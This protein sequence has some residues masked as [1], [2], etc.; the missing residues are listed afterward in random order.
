VKLVTVSVPVPLRRTFEYSV[1]TAFAEQLVPGTRVRVPFGRRQLIGVVLAAP[2]EVAAPDY[3][4]KP[5]TEVLDTQPALPPELFELC[6]WTADYYQHPIGEVFAAVLPGPLRRGEALATATD[7]WLRLGA[8]GQ[9][10]LATLPARATALRG[11]LEALADAPL[12]RAS[13][14]AERASAGTA[15]RRALAEGWVEAYEVAAQLPPLALLEPEPTL[16][17][18]QAAALAA[19]AA[20]PEGF[21]T[22][23]L[24]GVT[25]SGKTE[26]YLRLTAQVLAAGRQVLVLAPEI[27]LTPQLAERFA[28]RFGAGVARFHSG[29]GETERAQVWQAARDGTVRVIVGTRSAVFVPLAAP[30]LIIVDEEHDVSYKQQD[31]LRYA[32]RDVAVLR[33]SRL[34]VPV[35]LGSATP[36][37]ESRANAESGRYRHVQ[38]RSRVQNSAPPTIHLLDV[39]Q[40]PLE[41]GLSEPLL[42]AVARH[43][44]AGNQA[45]L[46]LNRRGYA[47]VLLCHDCGWMLPCPNCDARLVLH[48]G[49]KRMACHHCG[50]L[51]SVP[52]TCGDCGGS[53]LVPVGQGT[54]RIEEALRLRF[55]EARVERFDSDRLR[56]AAQMQKLF[57]DVRS[58]AVNLL[59]GTQVLAKGHDFAGLTFAGLVDVDQALY[60]SDFR[61]LERMGQLV[62]QVAG[63]V[64]R[65][66]QPG[67]V[68]LQTH[69]P[70]HPALQLLAR[71]GYPAFAAA[72]LRE[73]RDFELPPF[74]SLA[75]LRAEARREE[76]AL[77]FLRSARALFP[78]RD[79]S[80]TPVEVLGPAAAT[81]ARRAGYQHAQLL[82]KCRSRAK[83]HRAISEWLPLLESHAD[84]RRVRWSL[85]IDP[86]DLF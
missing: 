16:S 24:E 17:A 44:A 45:L 55:P 31:G 81:M 53:A 76:T 35:L 56:S 78:A 61:A 86:A 10:A 65:A 41:H 34:G 82:L 70:E 49:R 12:P 60:G 23:L 43:L 27:G 54:E 47:P 74:S 80:D 8:A 37:L 50:Q 52:T 22:R 64:G 68:L 40:Q 71:E 48:R 57:A 46:F 38:L 7:T 11:V 19:L 83:L 63:R 69:Q 28:A 21:S 6:R 59:V 39:R 9:Q 26:I 3:A 13:L 33:A 84:A 36:S 14:L 2:R 5:I 85:D 32:A 75:L 1:P 30:G 67:E 20:A 15:L 72:Q 66:G 25:G 42:V 73:R 18:E 58:G 62:T 29:I 77:A 4:C 51:A 79:G